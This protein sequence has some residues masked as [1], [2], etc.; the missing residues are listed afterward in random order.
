MGKGDTAGKLWLSDKKRFADLFNGTI[1]YGKQVIKAEELEMVRGESDIIL[2]DKKNQS[3]K[4]QRYRDI[5]MK[6]TFNDC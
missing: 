1:F 6:S 5:V 3:R 4:I 2:T